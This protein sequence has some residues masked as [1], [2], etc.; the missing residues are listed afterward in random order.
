VSVLKHLLGPGHIMS[1]ARSLRRS[2]TAL[3]MAFLRFS[4][5][6]PRML[7]LVIL[8]NIGG[9]AFGYWYYR[10]QLAATPL[11][12]WPLVPDSPNAVLL[13]TAALVAH[14]IGRPLRALDWL[15]VISMVKVGIWTVVVLWVHHDYF[16]VPPLRDLNL[17]LAV[18]HGSMA[19][20]AL[21]LL[22]R[23][24]P[25]QPKET[26]ALLALM[27]AMDGADYLGG[28]HPSMPT[29]GLALVGTITVAL[30]VLSLVALQELHRRWPS[31]QERAAK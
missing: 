26:A 21:I 1:P 17:L 8:T 23:M 28:L 24:A 4:Y 15:G 6:D 19:I 30:S 12:L 16:L 11:W 9:I 27:L 18:L 7:V 14:R 10:E 31:V 13:F 22:H 25:L 20:E 2:P 3:A 5:E 29:R